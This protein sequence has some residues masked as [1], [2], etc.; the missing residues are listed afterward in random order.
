NELKK[1]LVML[2]VWM[3]NSLMGKYINKEYCILAESVATDILDYSDKKANSR[4][5]DMLTKGIALILF[6]SKLDEL[7]K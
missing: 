5:K 1:R 4:E 2:S 3:R 6:G 7:S